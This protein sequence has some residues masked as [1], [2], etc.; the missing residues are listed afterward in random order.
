VKNSVNEL[1]C[2]AG[3]VKAALQG[4]YVEGNTQLSAGTIKTNVLHCTVLNRING[5]LYSVTGACSSMTGCVVP[6]NKYSAWRVERSA[7]ATC[8]IPAANSCTGYA[9]AALALAALPALT[10]DNTSFGTIV[11]IATCGCF[12]PNTTKLD[13]AKICITFADGT[14]TANAIT[15]TA[16]CAPLALSCV[17]V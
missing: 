10:A 15:G 11:A 3:Q 14:T 17:T 6:Q 12:V 2:L 13:C 1:Q 9:T 5:E 4:D 7:T 8:V 16:T